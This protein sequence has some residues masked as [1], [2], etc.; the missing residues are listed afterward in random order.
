M[1]LIGCEA[2]EE[3]REEEEETVTR[4]E[5]IVMRRERA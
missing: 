2:H 4:G 1:R 5:N 3:T